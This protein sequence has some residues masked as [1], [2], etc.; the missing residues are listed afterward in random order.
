MKC[1]E[2]NCKGTMSLMVRTEHKHDIVK[3]DRS[4]ITVGRGVETD[5]SDSFFECDECGAFQY[6]SD[7][8]KKI[9]FRKRRK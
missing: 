7:T 5:F 2:K 4:S 6:T 1:K 3:E 8:K 9:F